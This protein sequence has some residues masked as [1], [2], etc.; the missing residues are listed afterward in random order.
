MFYEELYTELGKLFYFIAAA[1]GKVQPAEKK[2]L[3]HL[4]KTKWQP[5]E[6]SADEFGTDLS[7]LIDFSFEYEVSEIGTENGFESFKEFYKIN[8]GEFDQSIVIKILE[9]AE[10]I[11]GAY[12]GKNKEEREVLGNLYAILNNN[13]KSGF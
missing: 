6:D 2:T 9:T 7:N 4:I 10:E 12:H 13:K 8:K 3:Q 1:D 5:L 11:A